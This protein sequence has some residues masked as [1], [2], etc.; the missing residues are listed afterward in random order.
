MTIPRQPLQVLE[1]RALEVARSD[2]NR[3][4]SCSLAVVALQRPFHLDAVAIARGHEI[5]ADQEKNQVGSLEILIDFLG[6]VRSHDM[7]SCGLNGTLCASKAIPLPRKKRLRVGAK[8]ASDW[9][10]TRR[11]LR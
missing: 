7:P 11:P 1:R 5:G 10:N 8:P 4:H 9:Q 6:P 2:K 3:N